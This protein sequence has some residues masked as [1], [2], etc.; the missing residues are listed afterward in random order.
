MLSSAVV[1]GGFIT[2]E[3]RDRRWSGVRCLLAAVRER[4]SASSE[5]AWVVH[6]KEEFCIRKE[7]GHMIL[8]TSFFP[9][10]PVFEVHWD[11]QYIKLC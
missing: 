10:P 8:K 7:S 3:G 5:A 6:G 2:R 9:L 11:P 1:Q 4:P